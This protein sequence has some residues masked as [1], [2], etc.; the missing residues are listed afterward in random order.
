[1]PALNAETEQLLNKFNS[2]LG[3]SVTV[4]DITI[5]PDGI[6]IAL[7]EPNGTYGGT[8]LT[9]YYDDTTYALASRY[10]AEEIAGFDAWRKTADAL[11]SGSFV[12]FI[13]YA[14]V[15][16]SVLLPDM[17]EEEI[18][19]VL[20]SI[21]TGSAEGVVITAEDAPEFWSVTTTV[22]GVETME[23]YVFYLMEQGN[24]I[25]LGVCEA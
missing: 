5:T 17:N 11:T 23:G 13:N 18:A 8:K 10:S 2:A 19:N 15:E 12:E 22:L 21:L 9:S 25:V 3:I 20:T 1:M 4:D 24:N 16:L 6:V 14:Q 7:D